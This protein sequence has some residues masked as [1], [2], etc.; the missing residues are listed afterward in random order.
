MGEYSVNYPK[1]EVVHHNAALHAHTPL[2]SFP[3]LDLSGTLEMHSCAF[4]GITFSATTVNTDISIDAN[5]KVKLNIY[6]TS[7]F[8]IPINFI[9]RLDHALHTC[10]TIVKVNYW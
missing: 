9:R 6:Y 3:S 5:A 7:Y 10:D 2:S 4:Y 8:L 1:G